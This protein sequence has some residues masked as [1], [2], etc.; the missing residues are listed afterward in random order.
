MHG[1]PCAAGGACL[2]ACAVCGLLCCGAPLRLPSHLPTHPSRV[3]L[4]DKVNPS[5]SLISG[6]WEKPNAEGDKE[7]VNVDMLYLL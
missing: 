5:T 2:R 3:Q 1:C 6:T 7:L 4:F